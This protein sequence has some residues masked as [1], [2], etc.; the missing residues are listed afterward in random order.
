MTVNLPTII[1]EITEIEDVMRND[2]R[3]YNRDEEK[4]V[5][6]RELYG[7][8][9]SAKV[10][11][12]DA[13]ATGM[14]I[15]APLS[16]AKFRERNPDGDYPTYTAALREA[17]DVMLG[18]PANERKSFAGAIDRLPLPLSGA[19]ISVLLD[20]RHF[21]GEHCSPDTVAFF[22]RN[23]PGGGI[24]H[25]WGHMAGQKMG[26][27]RAKLYAVVDAIDEP[28]VPVF[29]RWLEN[30]TDGQATAVYRKLAA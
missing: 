24:V 30:L 20:R 29:L 12:A 10:I 28:L 13:E 1:S 16:I 17:G 19:M 6:L 2:R 27:A 4:Q 9:E 25:E 15:L 26:T 21:V 7:Q 3:S 8:R 22:K 14:E 23:A 5:R 11:A 18:V